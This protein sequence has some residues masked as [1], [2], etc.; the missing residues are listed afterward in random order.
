MSVEHG[1]KTV[2]LDPSSEQFYALDETAQRIWSL[3]ESPRAADEIV[4]SLKAEFSAAEP[5]LAADVSAFLDE[6]SQMRLVEVR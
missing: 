6:M 1:Q 5:E 4:A 3:I 2:L